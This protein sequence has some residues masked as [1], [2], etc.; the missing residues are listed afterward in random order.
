MT[1][2]VKQ[3]VR[4]SEKED[5]WRK[6]ENQIWPIGKTARNKFTKPSTRVSNSHSTMSDSYSTSAGSWTPNLC[7]QWHFMFTPSSTEKCLSGFNPAGRR[8][9]I[10]HDKHMPACQQNRTDGNDFKLNDDV[11]WNCVSN[12]VFL[13]RVADRTF[14]ACV[15]NISSSNECKVIRLDDELIRNKCAGG[16]KGRGSSMTCVGIRYCYIL[17][18]KS[19]HV[20]WFALNFQTSKKWVRIGSPFF[21]ADVVVLL[22]SSGCELH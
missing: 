11:L 21:F 9:G 20:V 2:R 12:S 19:R 16:V 15:P 18:A 1:P 4:I 14:P 6:D 8:G 17:A 13:S 22:D 3:W 5:D 10:T 7:H